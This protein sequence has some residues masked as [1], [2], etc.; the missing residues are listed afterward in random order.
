LAVPILSYETKAVMEL[1]CLLAKHN[2]VKWQQSTLPFD[3]F[4]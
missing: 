1:F 2:C 3:H 4:Q